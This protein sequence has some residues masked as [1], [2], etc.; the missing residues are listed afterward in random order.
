MCNLFVIGLRYCVMRFLTDASILVYCLSSETSL[1]G[2][3]SFLNAHIDS[4]C[5]RAEFW[6]D[7]GV[8]RII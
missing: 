4:P 1:A 5:Y 7:A 2:Q 6:T 3:M 8:Q